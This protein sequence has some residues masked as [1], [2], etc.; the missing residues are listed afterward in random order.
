M[1]Q[2]PATGKSHSPAGRAPSPRRR[3]KLFAARFVS[4]LCATLALALVAAQGTP[5]TQDEPE[6]T[7]AATPTPAPPARQPP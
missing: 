2:E 3:V 1:N 7:E 6:Q 5:A 4:I